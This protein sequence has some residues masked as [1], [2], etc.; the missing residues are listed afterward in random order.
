VKEGMPK[1]F[2]SCGLN[3]EERIIADQLNNLFF[4][5]GFETYWA[6][7]SYS[8][9]AAW[10]KIKEEII[11]SDILLAFLHRREKIDDKEYYSTST[12]VYQ[13][14]AIG[15]CFG[16]DII[17]FRE[18]GI[19]QFEGLL[20]QIATNP[21]PFDREALSQIDIEDFCAA[22][23]YD[24]IRTLPSVN[25][26]FIAELERGLLKRAQR[27]KDGI[28]KIS[29]VI[30]EINRVRPDIINSMINRVPIGPV[31]RQLKKFLFVRYK[32]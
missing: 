1:V 2:I 25:K 19:K 3:N 4:E 27:R 23:I 28:E 17:V 12:S 9:R 32:K 21:I 30:S 15:F 7:R 29:Q 31:R 11:D 10:E 14:I 13:E 8:S 6:G 24:K 18:Q 20:Y 26:P 5:D 22:L 16:K